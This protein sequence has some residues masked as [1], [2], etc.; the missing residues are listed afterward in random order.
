[1]EP[2]GKELVLEE[3]G[4]ERKQWPGKQALIATGQEEF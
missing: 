4:T 2:P 1:M 3:E